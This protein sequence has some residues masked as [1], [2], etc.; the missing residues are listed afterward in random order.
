MR[1]C[2]EVRV[3]VTRS[4]G[5]QGILLC[6][7]TPLS[8]A[9]SYVTKGL[10]ESINCWTVLPRARV[11]AFYHFLGRIRF[12]E[13]A[14]KNWVHWSL[15]SGDFDG[16]VVITWTGSQFASSSSDVRPH[17]CSK[18]EAFPFFKNW[19]LCIELSRSWPFSFFITRPFSLRSSKSRSSSL[20]STGW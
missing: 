6:Q 12:F 16:W 3:I 15:W 1:Y 8:F 4:W 2:I 19:L 20:W 9:K 7:A 10:S 5:L 14:T 18:W 13:P 11:I 17:W